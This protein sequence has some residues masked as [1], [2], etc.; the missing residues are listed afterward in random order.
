MSSSGV[1]AQT[2]AIT[3][4]TVIS[5]TG[6]AP[7]RDATVIVRGRR[8]ES[9]GP[10]SSARVPSDARVIDGRG[11]FV[12]PGLIEMHAHTSKTRGSALGLY[13]ANG[14]TTIRD[15]GSEHAEVLQWRN[16]IRSGARV[17]PRMLIS[18]PYLESQRNIER[19]RRDPPESRVEPFERARIPVGTP[20]RAKQVVDSLSKLELDFFKIRTVQDLATYRAIVAAASANGKHVMGHA[21]FAP[22]AV[23]AAGQRGVDHAWPN[24]LDSLTREQRMVIWRNVARADV[25]VI[26]TLVVFTDGVLT[27]DSAASV[28]L[29]D[30]L[31]RV[32]PRRK[33]VSR[34]M[35]LDW[36]EQFS[37]REPATFPILQRMLDSAV[38][39][40]REMR[41]AGVR[42]M[43]GS[44]IAVIGLYPGSSIHKELYNFVSL[45]GA[46]PQEAIERA[47]R[48]P[49]EFL[50]IADSVGTVQVGRVADLVLLDADP[51]A[52][53]RN[54]S[55]ISAVVVGGRVYDRQGIDAILAGVLRAEDL[56]VN[57]WK[58]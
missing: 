39:N 33:Y 4:V 32:D 57:D 28:A 35:Y 40:Y 23:I 29:N 54:V 13:V 27:T 50:G 18:G 47:T 3:H 49:A 9:A 7:M 56:K 11:K 31:G 24:A 20:E 15:A 53:I 52:D 14:V 45:I 30:S 8:I 5:A 22:D 43:V 12:I 42:L 48:I 26:P 19:M 10:S 51:L 16:E 36:K 21:S 17:G 46:T 44:D 55:K 6:A 34:F 58:R 25:G 1:A 38:R 37:E 2:T 41:E